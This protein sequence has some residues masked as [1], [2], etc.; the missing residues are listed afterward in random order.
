MAKK[1]AETQESRD[2][3]VHDYELIFVVKPEV[4][5]EALDSVIDGVN[6][7]ITGKQGV[8]EEMTKWGRRRLAYPIKRALEGNY[9]LAHFK[10]SP[11]WSKDL[12]ANLKI[13]EQVLRHL[14]VRRDG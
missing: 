8:V 10:M 2:G 4:A 7:F 3:Q 14:L 6:Q 5:D 9:V 13:S 11:E 1:K 12:E